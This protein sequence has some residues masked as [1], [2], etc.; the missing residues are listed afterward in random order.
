MKSSSELQVKY[1][2]IRTVQYCT[3]QYELLAGTFETYSTVPVLIV[4][5]DDIMV[6]YSYSYCIEFETRDT[7]H[8]TRNSIRYATVG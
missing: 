8:E 4:E 1:G 3:V 2:Q 5:T 6:T 7:R